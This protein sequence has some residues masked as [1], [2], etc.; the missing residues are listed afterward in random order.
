MIRVSPAFLRAIR[1][2]VD[3]PLRDL[4]EGRYHVKTLLMRDT[5]CVMVSEKKLNIGQMRNVNHALLVRLET[6]GI[7]LGL[8]LNGECYLGGNGRAG[9]IGRILIQTG[10]DMDEAFLV[11]YV[12]ERG[13]IKHYCALT[14]EDPEQ[15]TLAE[16]AERARAAEGSACQ[17]FDEATNLLGTAIVNLANIYDPE[18]VVVFGNMRK[19]SDLYLDKLQMIM[20]Q[21]F[22]GNEYHQQI[23]VQLSKL[24]ANAGAKGAALF[25]I[26]EEIAAI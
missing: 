11:S 21:Y 5:N 16:I 1:D 12:C 13:F 2:W 19:Y 8:L 4:M 25:A 9:E 10:C 3:V 18:T 23:Q 26:D 7:G 6:Y 17:V 22:Y 24:E 20:D 14:G 15:V